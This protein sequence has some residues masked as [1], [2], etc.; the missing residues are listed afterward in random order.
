MPRKKRRARSHD[1]AL[2]KVVQMCRILV[3]DVH[4]A[5]VFVPIVQN[6]ICYYSDIDVYFN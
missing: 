1:L 3:D 4:H 5:E 2:T 6:C